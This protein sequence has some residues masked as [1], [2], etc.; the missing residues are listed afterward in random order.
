MLAS[1][2]ALSLAA[3]GCLGTE[4]DGNTES[5][6]QASAKVYHEKRAY[7][8]QVYN[9]YQAAASGRITFD[10]ATLEA[11]KLKAIADRTVNEIVGVPGS[12][13]Q[14]TQRATEIIDVRSEPR[15]PDEDEWSADVSL[16]GFE[17]L[18]L[19]VA[20]GTYR[21]LSVGVALDQAES[22]HQALEVC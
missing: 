3:A 6:D 12:W 16:S 7:A 13:I 18:G 17:E 10:V 20:E 11:G 9:D 15:D 14:M 2:I 5:Q 8:E 4:G 21:L 19:P 1:S 22:A